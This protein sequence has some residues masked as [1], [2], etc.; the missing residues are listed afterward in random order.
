MSTSG[1]IGGRMDKIQESTTLRLNALVQSMIASGEDIVNLTAGEPDFAVPEVAKAAVRLALDQNRS[2]YTPVAG[3]SELRELIAAKTNRQQP[4][5]AASWRPWK[6][7]DVVVS[8]GG[9]HALFNTL[10]CLLDPGEE[11]LIPSPYWLSYPDMVQIAGGIPKFI[12]TSAA[13]SFKITPESLRSALREGTK[14]KVKALILNSPSNPTGMMYTKEEFTELGNVLLSAPGAENVWVISDEIYDGIVFGEVPFASFLESS[15]ELH[16]RCVTINGM[17]KS[18]A[19]TGWR[20]GWTVAPPDLT[21][22]VSKLQGQST[23]GINSLAQW[24]SV[25]ALKLP[26]SA[27]APQRKLFHERRDMA[28]EILEKSGTMEIVPPQ[29]AFYFFLGVGRCFRKGE[30]SV[31]FAERLL[32]EAKVAVV[33]GAP[34]GDDGFVR[35]SFATESRLLQEGCRRIV[36]YMAEK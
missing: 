1:R 33:P 19:M 5:V 22:A 2:K 12:K 4:S 9:K 10:M 21:E 14:G 29:G 27:Y 30:D 26:E 31:S 23:S 28:L 18:A 7:S 32:K 8:N 6:G 13:T 17:S 34:F 25:A 20:V 16:P 24:A 35:L 36:D 3:V 11:V 15:P